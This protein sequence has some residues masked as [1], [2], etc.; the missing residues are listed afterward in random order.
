MS[1]HSIVHASSRFGMAIALGAG[2]LATSQAF[3][4]QKPIRI[5]MIPDAGATQVSVEQKAPLVLRLARRAYIMSVG[6]I[7][8]EIDPRQ[9]KSHDELA[10][11]YLG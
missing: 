6:S 9:V 7:A 10:H 2:L 3:A 4:D 5:G 1:L 8:A 11:F